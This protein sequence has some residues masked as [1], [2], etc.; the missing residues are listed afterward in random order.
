M[1]ERASGQSLVEF[2]LVLPAAFLMILLMFELFYIARTKLVLGFCADRVVRAAA[3]Q[4]GLPVIV[5][6]KVFAKHFTVGPFWGIPLPGR[7]SVEPLPRWPAYSGPTVVKPLDQGGSL[8]VVDLSYQVFPKLWL[9]DL[10]RVSPLG[11][12]V[13][14]PQEPEVPNL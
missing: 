1:A 9:L 2:S 4:E 12:H 3:V 5:E 11:A 13:E 6:A 7:L 10:I 8:A 14:L